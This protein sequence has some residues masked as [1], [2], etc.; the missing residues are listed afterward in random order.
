MIYVRDVKDIWDGSQSHVLFI[1]L[2]IF[3]PTTSG[4][5]LSLKKTQVFHVITFYFLSLSDETSSQKTFR[6]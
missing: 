6:R 5:I 1:E 4:C 2:I 3:C